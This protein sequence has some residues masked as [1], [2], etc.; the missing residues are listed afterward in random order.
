[1]KMY[2][3]FYITKRNCREEINHM[4]VSANTQKEAIAKCRK[5]VFEQT[6]KNAFRA[7]IK[8]PHEVHTITGRKALTL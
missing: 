4:F 3:V 2:Q 6:G 1:M 8:T 5:E 7:T